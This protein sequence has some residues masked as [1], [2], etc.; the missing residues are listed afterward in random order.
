MDGPDL[1]TV[2]EVEQS[3]ASAMER[4]DSLLELIARWI[5]T[6]PE[7]ERHDAATSPMSFI[8]IV[9][10]LEHKVAATELPYLLGAAIMRLAEPDE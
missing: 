7:E 10:I 1:H 6:Y 4:L 2:F 8:G 9:K 5:A 3:H